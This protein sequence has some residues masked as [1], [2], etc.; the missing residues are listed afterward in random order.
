MASGSGDPFPEIINRIQTSHENQL[1]LPGIPL[2]PELAWTSDPDHAAAEADLIVL[3][4]PSKFC[5]SVFA[6][7]CGRFPEGCP[8][9]SVG[10]GLDTETGRR[11]TELAAEFFPGHPLAALSG[12]NLA[13]EVARQMPSAVIAAGFVSPAVAKVFMGRGSGFTLP[14]ISS[15]WVGGALKDVSPWRW[16]PATGWDSATTPALL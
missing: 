6:N 2:P 11:L 9:L 3:A 8:L 5:R 16:A 4:I 1:Y 12:P 10:K 7:F 13:D 15:V 14:T